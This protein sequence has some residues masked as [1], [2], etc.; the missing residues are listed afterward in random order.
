MAIPPNITKEHI[1]RVIKRID[2]EVNFNPKRKERVW[3]LKFN[4]K[5]YPCKL[6]ISYANVYPYKKEL[7]SNPKVFTTYMAQRF[8]KSKGFNDIINKNT[9]S[10]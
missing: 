5:L 6:V 4:D 9:Y 1:I 10:K 7:D 3:A 8:L 2:D